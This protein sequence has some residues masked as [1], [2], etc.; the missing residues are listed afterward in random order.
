MLL[1]PSPTDCIWSHGS[2]LARYLWSREADR[3]PQKGKWSGDRLPIERAVPS[4]CGVRSNHSAVF[5]HMI[6]EA[7][8]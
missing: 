2:N 3:I 6:P 7:R 1:G 5:S 4:H 8:N